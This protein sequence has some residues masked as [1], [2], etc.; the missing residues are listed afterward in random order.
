MGTLTKGES[1]RLERLQKKLSNSDYVE[2]SHYHPGI[3]NEILDIVRSK[4]PDKKSREQDLH[5]QIHPSVTVIKSQM[6]VIELQIWEDK[7]NNK[8]YLIPYYRCRDLAEFILTSP[9]LYLF[10]TGI[11]ILTS[12][13]LIILRR[14]IAKDFRNEVLETITKE[15]SSRYN[16]PVVHK[17]K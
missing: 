15:Y 1:M 2:I 12:L 5:N 17:V 10:F 13:I 7:Q 16:V 3:G 11:M 8:T 4:Y 9:I 6:Q 14:S